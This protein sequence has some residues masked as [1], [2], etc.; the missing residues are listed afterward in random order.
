M[1][2]KTEEAR[3]FEAF[4]G[5]RPDIRLENVAHGDR[6]DFVGYSGATRVGVEVTRFSPVTKKGLPKPEEQESLARWTM[7]QAWEKY[8]AMGAPPLHVHA[9]FSRFQRLTKE[10]SPELAGEIAR[11]LAAHARLLQVYHQSDFRDSIGD[12]FLP[13][14][15]ALTACRVATDE[16]S[17]WYSGQFGWVRHADDIDVKRAMTAKESRVA[18]YRVGCDELW[19]LIVFDLLG[20]ETYVRPPASPCAFSVHSGFDRVFC[21]AP[22]GSMCV[23]VPV[24]PYDL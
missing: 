21:L 22:M 7:T 18:A 16:Q 12:D 3:Y 6:P 10:R 5:A 4:L 9:I 23:E 13:E 24:I 15:A 20:G 17:G 1:R 19:L 8:R 14:V 2:M 11:F